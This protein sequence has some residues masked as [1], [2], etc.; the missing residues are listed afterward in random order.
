M[1]IKPD[2]DSGISAFVRNEWGKSPE[3]T[4]R[5]RIVTYD[6]AGRVYEI[7]FPATTGP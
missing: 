7:H 2:T 1:E 3:W 5:G 6:S 4:G